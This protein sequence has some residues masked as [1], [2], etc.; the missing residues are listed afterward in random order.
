MG[1]VIILCFVA[2]F[3]YPLWKYGRKSKTSKHPNVEN[4]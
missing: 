2:Y 1:I 4:E 3:I